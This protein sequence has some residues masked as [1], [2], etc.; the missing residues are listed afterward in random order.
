MYKLKQLGNIG[1][2]LIVVHQTFLS[3][4]SLFILLSSALWNKLKTGNEPPSSVHCAHIAIQLSNK[5]YF[6][7]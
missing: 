6:V 3:Y 1:K 4:I 7:T 5:E 2:Y